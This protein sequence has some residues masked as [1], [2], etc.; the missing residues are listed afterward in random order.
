MQTLTGCQAV[1]ARSSGTGHLD[2]TVHVAGDAPNVCDYN[3]RLMV[4]VFVRHTMAAKSGEPYQPYLS[5]NWSEITHRLFR[6]QGAN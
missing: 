6:M 3:F 2:D 4:T 5:R 1:L